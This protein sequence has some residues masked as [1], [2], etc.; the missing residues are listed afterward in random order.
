MSSSATV[1]V[2]RS[3]RLG[4]QNAEVDNCVA[5]LYCDMNLEDLKAEDA[6]RKSGGSSLHQRRAHRRMSR[7][8]RYLHD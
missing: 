2:D 6:I 3:T 4:E 1:R 8:L 7:W 5:W